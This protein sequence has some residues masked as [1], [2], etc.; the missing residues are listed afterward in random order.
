MD[1]QS[2][3]ARDTAVAGDHALAGVVVR[4]E[5]A[6]HGGRRG[7]DECPCA[8]LVC[9]SEKAGAIGVDR[10][11][12]HGV[13]GEQ[14]DYAAQVEHAPRVTCIMSDVGAG[15]VAADQDRFG[16]VRADCGI[17]LRSAAAWS[18]DF[19][20]DGWRREGEH[21]KREHCKRGT[22]DLHEILASSFRTR[23]EISVVSLALS[24]PSKGL[25]EQPAFPDIPDFTPYHKHK[26][27]KIN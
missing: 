24:F 20:R 26:Q 9:T 19:P 10:V 1:R 4:H 8:A 27:L 18:D 3:H 13:E 11:W 2:G 23:E 17:E 22:K 15:H 6:L 7:I 12:V 14:A 25:Q 21:R 5:D 16:V